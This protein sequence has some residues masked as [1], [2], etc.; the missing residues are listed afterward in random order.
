MS[1]VLFYTLIL[2][3][4]VHSEAFGTRHRLMN[5]HAHSY[6]HL[7][8]LSCSNQQIEEVVELQAQGERLQWLLEKAQGIFVDRLNKTMTKSKEGNRKDM[9]KPIKIKFSNSYRRKIDFPNEAA[10]R[11]YLGLPVEQYSALNSSYISRSPLNEDEFILSIPFS[12]TKDVVAKVCI[13]VKPQPEVGIVDFSSSELSFDRKPKHFSTHRETH[14][15]VGSDENITIS[16]RE[17]GTDTK[18]GKA[19]TELLPKWLVTASES[20]GEESVKSSIQAV[21]NVQMKY[22]KDKGSVNSWGSQGEQIGEGREGDPEASVLAVRSKLSVQVNLDIPLQ[23]DIADSVNFPPISFLLGQ[24]GKLTAQLFINTVA[25][26]FVDLLIQDY[27]IRRGAPMHVG[28]R[29][30]VPVLP[31]QDF[32]NGESNLGASL[33][34][35]SNSSSIPYNDLPEK[36]KAEIDALLLRSDEERPEEL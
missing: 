8:P 6:A 10:A 5:R 20:E 17:A 25:P 14:D 4:L 18:S 31:L 28:V 2:S 22:D 35:H 27:N 33:F 23:A 16:S 21:V 19:I 12:S 11:H 3:I 13:A 24:A 7:S 32:P 15:P 34:P 1:W 29:Q 36:E 9:K 26:Y 30:T